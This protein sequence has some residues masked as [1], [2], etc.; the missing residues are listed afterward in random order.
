MQC[1]LTVSVFL[2]F[3]AILTT[4]QIFFITLTGILK[5]Y[6]SRFDV[7]V[8]VH[9]DK[10][11]I[12]KPTRC[13]NFSILLWNESLHVSD[14]SSVHHQEYF[15]VHTAMLYVIPVCGQLSSCPHTGMTYTIAVCT[16]KCSWRWTEELSEICIFSFQNKI[17]KFVHLVGFIVR[18]I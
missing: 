6:N 1:Y 5:I 8:T 16:V 17:E 3:C 12:I 14:S 11:R 18:K 2:V 10:F 15:T 7:Q 9:R 13:T 4:A